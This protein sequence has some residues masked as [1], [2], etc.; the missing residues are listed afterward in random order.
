MDASK[1]RKEKR[2]Q[3]REQRKNIA[4]D[5][6]PREIFDGAWVGDEYFMGREVSDKVLPRGVCGQTVPGKRDSGFQ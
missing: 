3:E 4:R 6:V 5:G 2:R 1:D